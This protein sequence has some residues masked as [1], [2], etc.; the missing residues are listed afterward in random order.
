[1]NEQLIRILKERYGFERWKGAKRSRRNLL[2]WR[3]FF[4]GR[5][6]PGYTL[7]NARTLNEFGKPRCFRSTW[8]KEGG[9][10]EELFN[11]DIFECD[12]RVQAHE[13]LMELT[14]R[15]SEEH[16]SEL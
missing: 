2:F 6:I 5:E 15:R 12:S 7:H 10:P 16:N 11:L 13:F 8:Q 1:M 14:Q 4:S 9:S 3:L